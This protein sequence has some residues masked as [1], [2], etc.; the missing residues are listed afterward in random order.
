MKNTFLNS[1]YD[2]LVH[3]CNLFR[4]QFIRTTPCGCRKAA[5]D[6]S[7]WSDASQIQSNLNLNCR[8]GD[9]DYEA[10]L[11]NGFSNKLQR[12]SWMI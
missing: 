9:P 3:Q 7:G 6:A 8:G 12:V 2:E 1:T 10:S 5:S 4:V 11:W